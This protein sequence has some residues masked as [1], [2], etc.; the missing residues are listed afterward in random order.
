M[1]VDLGGKERIHRPMM[2]SVTNVSYSI[3]L[4]TLKF[5]SNNV[6]RIGII[7]EFAADMYM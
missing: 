6:F 5:K 3:R 4:I 2:S 1:S 7:I